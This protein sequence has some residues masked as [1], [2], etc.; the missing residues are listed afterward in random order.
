M[1][2][3]FFILGFGRSGTT[4]LASM[5]S[6]NQN[7]YIP[8]ELKGLYTFPKII[9][10]YGDLS[11]EF[12]MNLFIN[13]FSMLHQMKIFDM[14]LDT[15]S[16]KNKLQEK[17]IN[18][19]NIVEC[20][21]ET[22]LEQSDK[23]RIGDKTIRHTLYLPMIHELFPNAKIIHLMRDGRDCALSHRKISPVYNV[24]LAATRWKKLNEVLLDFGEK[25]KER[26]FFIKYEE[27]IR[28]PEDILRN[29]CSFLD[30][31]YSEDLLNYSESGY[32]KDN[33]KYMSKQ[34]SNLESNIIKNNVNKWIKGLSEN[35]KKIF[36]SIAG[37]MLLR[38]DYKTTNDLSGL[39]W[40]FEKLKY[41]ISNIFDDL[42]YR[43]F[44]V[45]FKLFLTL[46]RMLKVNHFRDLKNKFH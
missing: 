5:L 23:K 25:N 35:E 26:Y 13:D 7:I 11:K 36:E 20:F 15:K 28:Q 18:N 34:H 8:P 31:P 12:N 19:R 43:G 1:K 22:I 44:S 16:F 40:W 32:A 4:L 42:K 27:F 2:T 14:K 30:E 10:Y 29:V 9:K 45:R 24:Y 6:M 3:P 41:A 21:Y 39:S 17:G 46:K 37:D 38:F 33:V